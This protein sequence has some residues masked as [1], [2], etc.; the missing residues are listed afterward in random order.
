M[1]AH[2]VA[3]TTR[4]RRCGIFNGIGEFFIMNTS[5]LFTRGTIPAQLGHAQ[6]SL[7]SES[8]ENGLRALGF[9]KS[10]PGSARLKHL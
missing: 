5:T 2:G 1:D 9:R 4:A 10:S 3:I 6:D 7:T 8:V